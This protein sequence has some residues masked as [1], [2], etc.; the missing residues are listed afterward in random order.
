MSNAA[1]TETQSKPRNGEPQRNGTTYSPRVDLVETENELVLI[2]D[3][4]GVQSEDLDIR[5]EDGELLIHGKI[6]PRQREG[7]TYLLQEYGT[8]D[9]QRSFRL[10][11]TI[12][13]SRISADLRNGVLKLN[14][15]KSEKVK[16]RRI[17]VKAG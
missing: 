17:E 13:P 12:D 7:Q 2:A 4:P 5:C 10:G 1:K 9:F 15:P 8:G 14:L 3:L 6:Q 16:P 11:E